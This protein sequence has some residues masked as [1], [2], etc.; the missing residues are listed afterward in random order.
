MYAHV[1]QTLKRTLRARGWTYARLGEAIGLSESGIKKIFA[2]DDGS[3]QRVVRICAVLGL[4]LDELLQLAEADPEPWRLTDEQERYFAREPRCWWFLNALSAAGW[5]AGAVA[6][7]HGIDGPRLEGWLSALERLEVIERTPGGTIRPDAA[8]GRPWQGGARFGDAV[9]APCQD[10]LLA[11]ARR[12]VRDRQAGPLP[13]VTECGYGEMT[14]SVAGAQAFKEAL[15]AVVADFAA[16]A[17]REAMMQGD[18]DRL[19]V[20]VLTAMAP[21]PPGGTSWAPVRPTSG[22]R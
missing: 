1:M 2:A 4:S 8:A 20:A 6:A 17:R 19:P 3:F 12:R 16:R 13:G 9:I 18:A 14:L 15:R 10:A 21:V 7:T 11:E 5:D 22:G